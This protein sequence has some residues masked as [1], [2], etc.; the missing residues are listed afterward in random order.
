M[1][2][3]DDIAHVVAAVGRGGD[4][5]ARHGRRL[6]LLGQVFLK[7]GDG[8]HLAHVAAH[9]AVLP[10][11]VDL[12][13]GVRAVVF[14]A[15]DQQQRVDRDA[16][17][18]RAGGGRRAAQVH[19]VLDELGV[20]A[21]GIRANRL[22]RRLRHRGR[23]RQLGLQRGEVILRLLLAHQAHEVG[24]DVA[25]LPA[26]LRQIPR[27]AIGGNLALEDVDDVLG[28]EDLL[29]LRVAGRVAAQRRAVAQ[30]ARVDAQLLRGRGLGGH[31][32]RGRLRRGRGRREGLKIRRDLLVAHQAQLILVDVAP[33]ALAVGDV[34]PEHAAAAR[35]ALGHVHDRVRGKARL[36]RGVIVRV[37]AHGGA[38]RQHERV[39]VHVL[40]SRGRGDLRR[41]RR[42]ILRNRR[43]GVLR[44][45]RRGVLRNRRLGVLR[46]RRRGI[47][48]G[49]R[50]GVLRHRRRG[51]LRNRRHGI[52]RNRGF[53]RH[54]RGLRVL[55]RGD[56]LGFLAH[57]H[58]V[59]V[60]ALDIAVGHLAVQ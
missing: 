36:Q 5:A 20:G 54:R 12:I 17:Q 22:R 40:R 35:N 55:Q 53:R 50:L 2:A 26:V 4:A 31:G 42:G 16:P 38:V 57:A 60:A 3:V 6:R 10:V 45:R 48:R 41:R 15:R 34:I 51:V 56:V 37:A 29:N 13:P 9:V 43:R 7:L 25:P 1:R 47:L 28:G 8:Q 30:H 49:R 21:G 39:G 23:R 32:G 19:R 52:L 44:H 46:H 58:Q 11:V 14:L 18:R 24:A 33:L 59:D 27:H